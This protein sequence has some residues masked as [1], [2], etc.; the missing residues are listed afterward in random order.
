MM[1]YD[2]LHMNKQV[3]LC[4]M[5]L[6]SFK[7]YII[8]TQ[9]EKDLT[10]LWEYRVVS[11]HCKVYGLGHVGFLHNYNKIMFDSNYRP[12]GKMWS[13]KEIS[14]IGWKSLKKYIRVRT[15]GCIRETYMYVAVWTYR[16]I[17]TLFHFKTQID[18]MFPYLR[19]YAFNYVQVNKLFPLKKVIVL[20][21]HAC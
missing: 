8:D 19:S 3:K 16:F 15:I 11:I 12:N 17:N 21:T 5:L 20:D 6:N 7:N 9:L 18:N 4:L 10:T 2:S 13:T 1:Y 14:E